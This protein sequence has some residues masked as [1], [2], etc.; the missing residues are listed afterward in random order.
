MSNNNNFSVQLR[1]E[2]RTATAAG[3]KKIIYLVRLVDLKFNVWFCKYSL[4]QGA[5]AHN[6]TVCV[7]IVL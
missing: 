2:R 5:H 7:C 1:S 6:V 4:V 3:A